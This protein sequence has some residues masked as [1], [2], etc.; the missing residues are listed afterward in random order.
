MPLGDQAPDYYY[1]RS[2][3]DRHHVW[4]NRCLRCD[5]RDEMVPHFPGIAAELHLVTPSAGARGPERAPKDIPLSAEHEFA[6]TGFL[7]LDY[8]LGG[9]LVEG[10]GVLT[11]G[12]PGIGKTTLLMHIAAFGDL[13]PALYI[14]GEQQASDL[15]RIV[16]KIGAMDVKDFFVLATDSAEEAWA[17]VQRVNAKLVITDSI[18]T[19]RTDRFPNKSAGNPI[20]MKYVINNL[21]AKTKK[22]GRTIFIVGQV[23][24]DGTFEGP[25]A[26]E[27][28][29]DTLLFFDGHPKKPIR[30]LL[31]LKN[32]NGPTDRVVRLKMTGKGLVE[33]DE[34]PKDGEESYDDEESEQPAAEPERPE[35][36]RRRRSKRTS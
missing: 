32:R 10:Q 14:S 7:S 27:H 5:A 13:K 29:V 20:V 4:L 36:G 30:T 23:N 12:A 18:Q 25:R 31:C 35:A 26:L 24:K 6:S 22:Q 19:L 15:A 21:C 3:G 9:G 2:C 8:L 16:K 33:I 17:A 1:C 28:L 34:V 11:G